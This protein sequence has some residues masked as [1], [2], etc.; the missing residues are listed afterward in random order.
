M[1][2]DLAVFKDRRAYVHGLE[3]L[4]FEHVDA[5]QVVSKDV[6]LGK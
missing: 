3:Q 4:A 5:C 6:V 2:Q 1:H